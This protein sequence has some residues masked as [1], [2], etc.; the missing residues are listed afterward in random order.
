VPIGRE[1]LGCYAVER[2]KGCTVE[3][4]S[5]A[6]LTGRPRRQLRGGVS[7]ILISTVALGAADISTG[8]EG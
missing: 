6:G 7:D 4:C 8:A 3:L 1:S 5:G 2:R